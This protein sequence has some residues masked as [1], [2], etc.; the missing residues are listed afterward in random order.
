MADQRDLMA[1]F[2]AVEPGPLFVHNGRSAPL[3]EYLLLVTA[4]VP[5]HKKDW[6]WVGEKGYADVT[7]AQ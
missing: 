5:D 1:A 4:L 3:A 7:R 6:R 2:R